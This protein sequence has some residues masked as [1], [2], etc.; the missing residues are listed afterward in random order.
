MIGA[1]AAARPVVTALA[2]ASWLRGLGALTQSGSPAEGLS[3]ALYDFANTIYSYAI[4]SYAMGLWVVDRLGPQTGQF[5]FGVAFAVSVGLNALVSPVLGAISDRAGRRLPFLMVFTAL[6]IGG[7]AVIAF[8]PLGGAETAFVGL[9]LF[10]ISNFAYQAALIYYDAT[11]PTVSRRDSRG[12]MSGIGVAV[13]YVGTIFIALLILLLGSEASPLTFLLAAAMFA[14][15]S[16][17]IF[18]FVHERTESTTRITA[19]QIASSWAQL[20]TT[21]RDARE[22]PGLPRFLVGRFFYTDPV[23]TVIVVMSVFATQAIGMTASQANLVLLS[24]TVAAVIASFL[25]GNLVERIGPKRTLMMVLGTWVIGLFIGGIYLSVP[26]F[27]I[28]GVLLGAALGGVWTSD[29]VFMLRLSPP[30]KVGEFF[31]LYGLA[32]KFSAVTGPLLYGAVVALLLPSLGTVAYQVAIFS[33]LG[34]MAVGFLLLRGVPEPP[35][36][37]EE[38]A[39]GAIAGRMESGPA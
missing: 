14:L 19:R 38:L 5:W 23:N 17:P 22:V 26:T 30:D 11:L 21:I 34:L 35:V 32:G 24:L 3:W 16:I 37:A 36:E 6:C 18:L 13:G 28:A 10:A 15:F 27:L 1:D 31:G 20:G 29:R 33:L 8:V 2:P 39:L 12:R 25:W 9:T 4:V 7:T